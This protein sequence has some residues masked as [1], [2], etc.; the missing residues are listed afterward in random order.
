MTQ[1]GQS[2]MRGTL[3][4]SVAAFIN[5]ILGFISGMAINE[6]IMRC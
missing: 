1:H 4:L 6:P 2:F 5:R 3:V